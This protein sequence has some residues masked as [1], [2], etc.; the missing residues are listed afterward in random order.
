MTIDGNIQA[1][2]DILSDLDMDWAK[3]SG[4]VKAAW[5]GMI[6]KLASEL[7]T[8]AKSEADVLD[9]GKVRGGE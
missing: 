4:R 6:I 8:V 1:M 7:E 3:S 2:L 9:K 5:M